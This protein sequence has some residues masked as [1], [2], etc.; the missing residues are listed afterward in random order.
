MREAQRQYAQVGRRI[1]ND[2]T[3]SLEVFVQEDLLGKL[4]PRLHVVAFVPAKG[5]STRVT[6]KNIRQLG[7]KPLF[8]HILDTLLTCHTIKMFI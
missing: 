6:N 4:A 7:D 8:L 5:T 2:V 3:S 1:V